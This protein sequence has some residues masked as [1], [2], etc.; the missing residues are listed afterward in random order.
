MSR[1]RHMKADQSIQ[2]FNIYLLL[3]TIIILSSLAS[4][5]PISNGNDVEIPH[6]TYSVPLF[7]AYQSHHAYIY[8]GSP[9]QRRLVIVD[10]GSK[11]LVFPC[12]PCQ[13]CG[14]AHF[15]DHY[16]S[17]DTSTSDIVS[18]CDDCVLASHSVRNVLSNLAFY[19]QLSRI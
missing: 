8:I 4:S 18:P 12:Q 14:R 6:T 1:P 19:S 7:A 2:V 3:L 16:F 15:S 9:A 17:L 13:K 11:V 10:T 5:K